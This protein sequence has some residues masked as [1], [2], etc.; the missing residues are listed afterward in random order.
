MCRVS[1]REVKHGFSARLAETEPIFL[2][3]TEKSFFSLGIVG[4]KVVLPVDVGSGLQTRKE[5]ANED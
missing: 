3:V 5:K 1:V 4:I 2:S